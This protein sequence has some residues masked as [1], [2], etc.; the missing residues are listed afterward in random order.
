ML[1]VPDNIFP[2]KK[3]P[4]I[5]EK[6]KFVAENDFY[7]IQIFPISIVPDRYRRMLIDP[8]FPSPPP[9]RP[10]PK[11]RRRRR[12]RCLADVGERWRDSIAGRVRIGRGAGRR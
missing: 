11:G 4:K 7:G 6:K 3:I 12:S 2:E 5:P 10:P 9:T 1:L 8:R